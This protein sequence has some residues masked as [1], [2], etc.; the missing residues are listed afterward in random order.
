M[1]ANLQNL[2]R[3]EQPTQIKDDY[4]LQFD[5]LGKLHTDLRSLEGEFSCGDDDDRLDGLQGGVDL[6]DDRNAIGTRLSGSIL[7]SC[8]NILT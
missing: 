1:T 5:V 8:Q 6:L 3:T 2:S 7:R 4:Y